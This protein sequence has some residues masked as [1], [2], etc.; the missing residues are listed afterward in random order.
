[1]RI[2]GVPLEPE[3][4]PAVESPV[5]DEVTRLLGETATIFQR[6]NEAGDMLRVATTVTNEAGRRAIGTYIPAT[7]P[8]GAP[9]PVIAAIRSGRTYHGRAF[10]VDAW[11]L[12]AY[13]PIL[14]ADGA[15]I[16]MLYVGI[17]QSA[18]EARIRQAILQTRAGKTG[19]VYVLGGTGELRGRYIISQDGLR[20]GE[21][22]WN[23]QDLDGQ[24]VVQRIIAKA[25]A[26]EPGQLATERYRWQNPGDDAP[27]WKTARLAYYAPWDW[28]IGTGVARTSW[29]RIAPSSTPDA[30]A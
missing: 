5:V 8:D 7:L 27:H 20:D 29:T 17:Q 26:L 11:H 13:E 3:A 4:D 30:A 9:N 24:P 6:M 19:Y 10:V 12:A 14:S 22:I 2:G 16:G 21:D 1:M 18:A 28:V 15:L 23:S 25:T